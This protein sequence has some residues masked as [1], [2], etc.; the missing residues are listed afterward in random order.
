MSIAFRA[1]SGS[2][3]FSRLRKS[4]CASSR[5]RSTRKGIGLDGSAALANGIFLQIEREFDAK[6]SYADMKQR[7]FDDEVQM[8]RVLGLEEV[9]T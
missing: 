4:R 9:N 2:T 3:S 6:I 1:P 7:I 5:A 8:L